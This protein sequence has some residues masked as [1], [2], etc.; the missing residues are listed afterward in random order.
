MKLVNAQSYRSV[1]IPPSQVK[2]GNEEKTIATN[3]DAKHAE[4]NRWKGRAQKICVLKA[5]HANDEPTKEK[6]VF[7]Q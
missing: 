2:S 5:L 7:Q 3:T 4:Y 6:S 1:S